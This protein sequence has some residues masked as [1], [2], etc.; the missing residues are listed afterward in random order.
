MQYIPDP[1]RQRTKRAG[2]QSKRGSQVLGSGRP[3][4]GVMKKEDAVSRSC[5]LVGCSRWTVIVVCTWISLLLV[6]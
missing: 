2:S 1:H 3:S 5:F 6:Q 4:K